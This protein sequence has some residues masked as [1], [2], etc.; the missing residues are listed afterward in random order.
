LHANFVILT[1]F[2]RQRRREEEEKGERNKR[3]QKESKETKEA[4]EKTKKI[5]VED[6]KVTFVAGLYR[7]T[8]G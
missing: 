1:N 6:R 8:V 5:E 4:K 7:F 2:V 3:K